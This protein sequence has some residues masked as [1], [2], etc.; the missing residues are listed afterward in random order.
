MQ[1]VK[2]SK[3]QERGSKKIHCKLSLKMY[4]GVISTMC[5]DSG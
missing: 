1:E 3:M 5:N 4:S 2:S